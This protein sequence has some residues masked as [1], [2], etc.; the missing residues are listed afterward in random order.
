M[1]N[2]GK[3]IAY[4]VLAIS[5]FIFFLYLTFPYEVLKETAIL[6]ASEA[7][8]LSL[9]IGELGPSFPLGFKGKEIKVASTDYQLRFKSAVVSLSFLSFF[10]GKARVDL[11]LEDS[12]NGHL[13]CEVALSILDII[14]GIY[15]PSN[16]YMESRKFLFGQ[17][18]DFALNRQAQ[19]PGVN[20]MLKPWL[21]SVDV[22]GQLDADIDLSI[23][24]GDLKSSE[25]TAVVELQNTVLKSLNPNLPI[26]DQ[27]F[28]KALIDSKLKNGVF[29]IS[30]KSGFTSQDLMVDISGKVTQKPQ[31]MRSTIDFSLNIELAA[32]L[33][34]Q[35]GI[36]FDAL[37]QRET[38]GKVNIKVQGPLTP[39]PKVTFL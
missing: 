35:F 22:D 29:T 24:S 19:A 5:S 9:E 6:K 17:L 32:P 2:F 26:P 20:L 11:S 10:L 12:K 1:K 23:D 18:V 39:Q 7:T 28:T 4:I 37:A 27:V 3:L 38:K 21:E 14:K 8:G 34:E 33:Q 25:G 16:I 36:I 31:L 13:D 15:M 30:K